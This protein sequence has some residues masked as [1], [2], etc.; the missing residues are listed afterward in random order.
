MERFFFFLAVHGVM[1]GMF[2]AWLPYQAALSYALSAAT[3]HA[4]LEWR[5]T[6]TNQK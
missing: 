5:R 3:T 6:R 4:I 1:L 2:W